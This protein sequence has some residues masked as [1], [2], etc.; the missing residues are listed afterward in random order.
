[1]IACLRGARQ[2]LLSS[3]NVKL[4]EMFRIIFVVVLLLLAIPLFNKGKEYW[5]EKLSKA[6]VIVQSMEKAIRYG[7]GKK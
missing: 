4:P 7:A 5:D 2:F 1:M 3:K 6:K